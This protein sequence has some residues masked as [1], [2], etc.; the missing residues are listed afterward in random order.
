[1]LRAGFAGSCLRFPLFS[2]LSYH[3]GE[4]PASDLRRVFKNY[5][6]SRKIEQINGAVPGMIPPFPGGRLFLADRFTGGGDLR[7][8]RIASAIPPLR[9]P[10]TLTPYAS[11]RGSPAVHRLF[12]QEPPVSA[13]E[14]DK[15]RFPVRSAGPAL[16]SRDPAGG[17]IGKT[18]GSGGGGGNIY[19]FPRRPSGPPRHGRRQREGL[20]QKK[21]SR[22]KVRPSRDLISAQFCK[23]LFKFEFCRVNRTQRKPECG[24]IEGKFNGAGRRGTNAVQTA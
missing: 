16:N 21:R 5:T 3:I 15:K 24:I 11:K 18:Q 4:I 20:R 8:R 7:D 17:P 19:I 1:M 10:P 9:R 14:K 23:R 6:K 2:P 12:H 22:E 13:Q